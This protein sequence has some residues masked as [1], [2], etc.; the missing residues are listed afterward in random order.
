M[1]NFNLQDMRLIGAPTTTGGATTIR[2]GRARL[3]KVVVDTAAADGV[4]TVYDGTDTTGTIM[5]SLT[6]DTDQNPMVLDYD[7]PLYFATGIH[8]TITGTGAASYFYE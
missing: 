6:A 3:R 5:L 1:S 8:V 2:T 7:P 4:V